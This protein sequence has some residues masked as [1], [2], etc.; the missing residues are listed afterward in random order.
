[1]NK[2][3]ILSVI[4]ISL[5]TGCVQQPVSTKSP[6]ELQAVQSKEFETTK[7]I[8]FAATL[9]VLQDLGYIVDA[10]NLDTGLITAK[11]PTKQGFVI[12]VGQVMKNVKT[13][14]FVEEITPGKT[15]IRANFVNSQKSSSGYGMQGE[16]ET[17]IETP[18]TYQDFFTRIQQGVFIRSNT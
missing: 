11:S 12:F 9:S 14:V 13:S 2:L 8:A 3:I 4:A 15:K 10:A 6:L 5:F 16:Q 7:K 1:M 18:D 17:P